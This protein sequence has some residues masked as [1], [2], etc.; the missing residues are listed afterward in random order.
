LAQSI[1]PKT[2]V[3]LARTNDADMRLFL[4]PPPLQPMSAEEIGKFEGGV[5]TNLKNFI[6]YYFLA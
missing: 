3:G 5:F 2:A 1:D 6:A 4:P